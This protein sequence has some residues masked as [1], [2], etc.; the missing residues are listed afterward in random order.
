MSALNTEVATL[1]PVEPPIVTAKLDTP[2][3]T[4]SDDSL[5]NSVS[6]SKINVVGSAEST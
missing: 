6:A 2:K 1:P 3:S 4:L 5:V